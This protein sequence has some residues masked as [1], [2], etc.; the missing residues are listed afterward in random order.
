MSF[1]VL[2]VTRGFVALNLHKLAPQLASLLILGPGVTIFAEL[3]V[4]GTLEERAGLVWPRVSLIQE[5]E[6]TRLTA[7][8]RGGVLMVAG[9]QITRA[10]LVLQ[11]EDTPSAL[12][13]CIGCSALTADE[14][15]LCWPC[16]TAYRHYVT[17]GGRCPA[18]RKIGL[19][20]RQHD[21]G[22][23]GWESCT[24]CAYTHDLEGHDQGRPGEAG[25]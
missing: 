10:M 24:K 5:G 18:C 6:E 21:S 11:V 23:G 17:T 2:P 9:V 8:L 14:E 19:I 16:R 7:E 13:P 20:R 25:A 12:W 22:A 1:L 15:Q 4:Q 3:P